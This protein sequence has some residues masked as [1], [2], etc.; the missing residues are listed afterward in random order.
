MKKVSLSTI[1]F[2]LGC[3]IAVIAAGLQWIIPGNQLVLFLVAV[4]GVAL[5]AWQKFRGD[6]EQDQ[7]FEQERRKR[8]ATEQYIYD[9]TPEGRQRAALKQLR[10]EMHVDSQEP[11]I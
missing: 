2:L 5:A 4:G 6:Y 7:K 3:F 10:T 9:R 11:H 1:L 8:E